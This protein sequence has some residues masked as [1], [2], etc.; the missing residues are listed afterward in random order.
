[1]ATVFRWFV[2]NYNGRLNC[3]FSQS[4]INHQSVVLISVSEGKEP[5]STAAPERFQGDAHIWVE[6]ISPREG[7]VEFRIMVN[8]FEPLEIWVDIFIADEFPQGW[9]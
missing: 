1:M 6:N 8:W 5:S 2:G 3:T 7:A 4:A 9:F